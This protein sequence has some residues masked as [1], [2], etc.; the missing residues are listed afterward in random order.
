M[1]GIKPKHVSA[2]RVASRCAKGQFRKTWSLLLANTLQIETY[3]E[4]MT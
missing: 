2:I 4:I 3:T 1:F